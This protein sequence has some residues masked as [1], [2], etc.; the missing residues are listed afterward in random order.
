MENRGRISATLTNKQ[1]LGGKVKLKMLKGEEG[2]SPTIS[3]TSTSKGTTVTVTDAEGDHSFIVLNG[4]N[5]DEGKALNA[6]KADYFSRLSAI[7][8]GSETRVMATITLTRADGRQIM[9]ES[10]GTFPD[11]TPV[12]EP[13]PEI[14]EEEVPT[15]EQL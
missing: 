14:P 5:G 11:M 3:T 7:Y 6:A 13:E 1:S 12:S 15:E 4:E 2:F 9:R 10:I 8:T